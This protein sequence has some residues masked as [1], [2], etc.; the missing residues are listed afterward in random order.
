V[1]TTTHIKALRIPL[2]SIEI[3][4]TIVQKLDNLSAETEKLQAIYQKKLTALDALKKSL[5]N[6]AFA[7]EL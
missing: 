6:Q 7:G 4:Q 1:V 3:Q 5:L 2:P